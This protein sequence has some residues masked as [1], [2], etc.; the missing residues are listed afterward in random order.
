MGFDEQLQ[1]KMEEMKKRKEQEKTTEVSVSRV[2]TLKELPEI[3][4]NKFS[5]FEEETEE[6]ISFLEKET[7]NLLNLQLSD[8]L[9]L[10]KIIHS[11]YEKFAS[12]GSKSGAYTK[13]LKLANINNK[14]AIRYRKKFLVFE[15]LEEKNKILLLNNKILDN[16]GAEEITKDLNSKGEITFSISSSQETFEENS[17][18]SE[19]YLNLFSSLEKKINSSKIPENIKNKVTEKMEEI[20]E[21]LKD[22]E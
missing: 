2:F 20:L 15:Q 12:Q 6:E 21:L 16:L 1:K 19:K 13:W 5:I 18:I 3:L 9:E 14:T 7:I 4:K 10:G 17:F 11:V 22:L 8:T